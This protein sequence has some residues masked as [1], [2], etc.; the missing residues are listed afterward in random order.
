[1]FLPRLNALFSVAAAQPETACRPVP[2]EL[3]LTETNCLKDTRKV[4]GDN[5]MKYQW[6]V[7]QLMPGVERPS[8]AGLRVVVLDRA[9]TG[10][11]LVRYQREVVEY[12]KEPQCSASRWGKGTGRSTMPEEPEPASG[13]DDDRPQHLS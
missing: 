13:L 8:A 9:P 4:A 6:L 7:L 1:M 5:M 3:S 2:E 12:Q 11:P 10:E